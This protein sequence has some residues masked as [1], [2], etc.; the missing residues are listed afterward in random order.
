MHVHCADYCNYKCHIYNTCYTHTTS[1]E[2]NEGNRCFS[3]KIPNVRSLPLF[4]SPGYDGPGSL[5][6]KGEKLNGRHPWR[7]KFK[8]WMRIIH[9]FTLV[10]S[11]QARLKV[12]ALCIWFVC[13]YSDK[14]RNP[15][16]MLSLKYAQLGEEVIFYSRRND[17]AGI[18]LSR[19]FLMFQKPER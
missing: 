12:A 8:P 13:S 3:W 17:M 4:G 11:C 6:D 14:K 9:S 18:A 7:L 15:K 1:N 5:T 19:Q 10:Y 2:S 16:Q